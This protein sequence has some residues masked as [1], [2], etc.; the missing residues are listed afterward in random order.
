MKKAVSLL[1]VILFFSAPVFAQGSP[2]FKACFDTI[3]SLWFENGTG[4]G[5]CLPNKNNSMDLSLFVG[6]DIGFSYTFEYSWTF[7]N[8]IKI[9]LLLPLIT[10]YPGIY[11]GSGTFLFCKQLEPQISLSHQ[12]NSLS[13]N[14]NMLSNNDSYVLALDSLTIKMSVRL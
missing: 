14:I 12:N 5:I 2:F 13:I 1:A 3:E 11:K 8:E 7:A 6:P 4:Y 10:T 9:N